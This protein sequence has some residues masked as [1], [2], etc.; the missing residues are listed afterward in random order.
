ML[1]TAEPPRR[2]TAVIGKGVKIVGEIY[3]SEDLLIEGFV[4]GKVEALYQKVTVGHS[5]T[6]HGDV[7]VRELDVQGTVQGNVEAGDR[8]D[9]RKDATLI[10]DAKAARIV[11]EDG[12]YFKG[13]IDIV[14]PDT[15]S[16]QRAA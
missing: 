7:Q 1:T 15:A 6:L 14:K 4:Q 8:V 12:G 3:T 10:G 2:G 5:G 11:L 13:S 9:V 16:K